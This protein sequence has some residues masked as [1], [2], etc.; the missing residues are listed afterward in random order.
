MW[1]NDEPVGVKE[2]LSRFSVRHCSMKENNDDGLSFIQEVV[3][4]LVMASR[5]FAAHASGGFDD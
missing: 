3:D 4:R 2:T 1:A 5:P